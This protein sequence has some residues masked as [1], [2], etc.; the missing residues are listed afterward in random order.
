MNEATELFR[1]SYRRGLVVFFYGLVWLGAAVAAL[2]TLERLSPADSSI[3]AI[4]LTA[5]WTSAL[6]GGAGGAAAMLQR[7]ARNLAAPADFQRYS[8]LTY[9]FQPITGLLTGIASLFIIIVPTSLLIN[10]AATHTFVL[11][12]LS[13]SS[14]GVALQ[15]L[16]AGIAGY[17]QFGGL[18]KLRAPGQASKDTS[19]STELITLLPKN[20]EHMLAHP[21]PQRRIDSVLPP[22][23]DTT[24]R[25]DEGPFAFKVWFEQR[26]EM[27]HW[28]LTWGIFVFIYGLVWL[29]GLIASLLRSGPF[30]EAQATSSLPAVNLVA[31][32]W[33]ATVAGGIGGVVGMYSYLYRHVSVKQDFHRQHLMSYLI[34]PVLGLF[35]GGAIYFFLTSGYLSLQSISDEAP[36]V[37]DSPT[38]IT[39]QV[40]LGWLA[41]FRPNWLPR[42]VRRIVQ[43][44]VSFFRSVLVRPSPRD[45]WDEAGRANTLSDLARQAE[46]L[47]PRDRDA[48]KRKT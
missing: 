31:A 32:A 47:R 35:W 36:P 33:V 19:D 30:F 28:S 24:A 37:V 13:T 6:A 27:I 16:L 15:I 1:Q 11:D 25:P 3:S 46:L 45:L 34:Q 48:V 14:A 8:L 41:G 26:Q 42:L 20:L 10:Y 22:I 18:A 44:V 2:L 12:D 9:F 38:L 29:V 4:L 21:E 7:L 17:Y 5:T 40:V 39:I 43:A 23:F